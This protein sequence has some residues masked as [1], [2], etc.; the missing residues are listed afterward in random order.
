MLTAY[1]VDDEKH[2]LDILEL[3]LQQTELVE[4][5]GRANSGYEALN[6]MEHTRPQVW[7]LDIQMPGMSG[8]ELAEQIIEHDSN[9]N[10]VFI[11][12]YHQYAI[13]AFELAAIDYVLKPI[14]ADRLLKTARRLTQETKLKVAPI[15]PVQQ[16]L[17]IN[18]L[19]DF[20]ISNSAG[21][22][23]V[24]RIAKEKELLA[25][26]LLHS[27]GPISR[28]VLIKALWPDD[29]YEKAKIHL[30]T[31]ISLLRKNLKQLGLEKMITYN[32]ASYALDI[33][34]IECD[35]LQLSELIEG[36]NSAQIE[37]QQL[38]QAII[39]AYQE[40]VLT[41]EH[42][43]WS[44]TIVEDYEIAA[45]T[46]LAKLTQVYYEAN[47][48]QQAKRAAQKAIDIAPDDEEASRW[49]SKIEVKSGS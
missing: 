7:F 17:H 15:E 42:Y 14:E 36:Y 6:A 43:D 44:K 38:L 11:T 19:G 9:A 22:P 47:E 49:L 32:M 25:Y 10:I 37:P 4:V 46:A 21:T 33:K 23:L 24:F 39:D 5:I 34:R 16:R 40:H 20:Q 12:A 26:M 45:L 18:I 27:P 41:Y 8:I 30:H 35:M 31:T 2:S 13:K 29:P 48:L 28:D 3:V 1:L